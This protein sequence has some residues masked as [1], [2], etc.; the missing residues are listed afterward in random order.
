I[1]IAPHLGEPWLARSTLLYVTGDWAEAVR[2]LRATTL[3]VPGLLKPRK[4]LGAMELE[5]GRVDEGIAQ[6]EAV[7][8]LDPSSLSTRWELARAGALLGRW[9]R[10]D[11]LLDLPVEHE[12]ESDRLARS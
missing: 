7:V 9:D 11:A 5:V 1:A 3:R 10:V 6:L 4:M 12:A 8:A 2:A